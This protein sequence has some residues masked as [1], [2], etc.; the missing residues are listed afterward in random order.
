MEHVNYTSL[1][2]LVNNFFAISSRFEIP[3]NLMY[4]IDIAHQ[5]WIFV[6]MDIVHS[7]A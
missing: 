6:I 7:H 5:N 4:L 1:D 3:E 2:Y